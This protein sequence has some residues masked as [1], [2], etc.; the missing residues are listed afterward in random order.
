MS[1]CDI[2]RETTQGDGW[3]EWV[4]DRKR[5]KGEKEGNIFVDKRVLKQS[6]RSNS[7]KSV[8]TTSGKK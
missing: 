3:K 4:E 2:A 6:Q 1:P 8:F 5:K 7:I